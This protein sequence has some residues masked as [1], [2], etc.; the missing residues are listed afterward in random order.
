MNI[1]LRHMADFLIALYCLTEIYEYGSEKVPIEIPKRYKNSLGI[2]LGD[3]N[4][5]SLKQSAQENRGN[6]I[7]KRVVAHGA[8]Q[9]AV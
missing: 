6:G 4:S 7:R 8:L 1:Y 3:Y 5:G 9:K 2:V